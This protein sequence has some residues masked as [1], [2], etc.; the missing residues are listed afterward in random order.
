LLWEKALSELE[1]PTI[2]KTIDRFQVLRLMARGG[3]AQVYEVQDQ[4]TG[5][6]L[7]LKLLMASGHAEDRFNREY[8]AMIRLNHPNIVRVFHYGVHVKTPWFT[9]ELVDGTQAQQRVKQLGVPGAEQ[10]THEAV[11]L[12]GC[13][14]SALRHAH[15][16]GLVHRD[17]KSGNVLVLP[18]GRVKLLDF[19]SARVIDADRITADGEFVG[20]FAYASPEQLMG[21]PADA[22]SDLYSLGVLSYR[23]LVG[24]RPF[25]GDSVH[26][27]SRKHIHE[28]PVPLRKIVAE[29]PAELD[30]L[31]MSLLNK[32][33]AAR[34]RSAGQV[35]RQ[36]QS[37]L[38]EELA[39][40]AE[41][42]I[43]LFGGSLVGREVE[44]KEMQHFLQE[45][46]PGSVCVV[47]GTGGS[48]AAELIR[49]IEQDVRSRDWRVFRCVFNEEQDLLRMLLLLK[50]LAATFAVRRNPQVLRSLDVVERLARNWRSSKVD[51][52]EV[53]RVAGLTLFQERYLVDGRPIVVVLNALEVASIG[54]VKLI[55]S[56]SRDLKR[57][58]VPV[59]FVAQHERRGAGEL[60]LLREEC[61]SVD[62]I[63]LGPLDEWRIGLRVGSFL[64]RRPPPSSVA[65]RILEA[66]GG[67]PEFVEELVLDLV[68]GGLIQSTQKESNRVDWG[69]Q[70]L[71]IRCPA[72]VR[73]AIMADLNGLPRLFLR[74]LEPLAV[75]GTPLTSTELARVIG[76]EEAQIDLVAG[77]LLASTW[78]V[79]S[80]G[81]QTQLFLEHCLI[82]K[83]I[84]ERMSD[85]RR[86]VYVR[87]VID[88][89]S[90]RKPS[91]HLV[92]L[93]VEAD[94]IDEAFGPA[95]ELGAAHLS[96][97]Q[98]RSALEV[99]MPV[100]QRVQEAKRVSR[101]QLARMFLL[102]ARALAQI[103]PL[104]KSFQQSIQRASEL[105]IGP[106]FH[107]ELGL[108]QA[109][110]QKWLGH[111]PNYRRFLTEAWTKLEEPQPPV[112]ASEIAANLGESHTLN[113]DLEVASRWYDWSRDFARKENSDLR[114]AYSEVGRASLF[115][116]QGRLG[117]A[118]RCATRALEVFDHSENVAGMSLA[119][120]IWANTLRHQ[121][122]FSQSLDVLNN[123]SPLLR[124][125][126]VP[127]F[128]VRILISTAR[129]E[130]DLCRLGR[131]QE[132]LDELD[133]MLREG[134]HF[135][136]RMQ[137][138][139]VRGMILLASSQR[140]RAA[141]CLSRVLERASA[142]QLV[143]EAER[144]RAILGEILW[145]DGNPEK[146]QE[147]FN[148]AQSRLA[149]VGHVPGLMDVSVRAARANG[150]VLRPDLIFRPVCTFMDDQPTELVRLEWS[151]AEGE[152]LDRH[153]MDASSA[154]QNARTVFTWIATHLNDTDRTALQLH[155]W[156]RKIRAGLSSG[157]EPTEEPVLTDPD[158]FSL[159]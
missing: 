114:W 76:W 17:L 141:D 30:A 101:E 100:V 133:A 2:S 63:A 127:T 75:A 26:E 124:Q 40:G 84:L 13:V 154:W 134:E 78:L 89:L 91:R 57:E 92:R 112:L 129:C 42:E 68:R 151:I 47:S 93:L 152:Y 86:L 53:L 85:A 138:E 37:M 108:I 73:Q 79:E 54:A 67:M 159:Q 39:Q 158:G 147:C 18:D 132:C 60:D 122:R 146:A 3:T 41:P 125:A 97:F 29:I 74:L 106:E 139:L 58:Q 11:R 6:H 62:L 52:R 115:Y 71:A 126:E 5:E 70:A 98:P 1:I 150:G 103:D 14:A 157:D 4:A 111:Y 140:R 19:G 10:R 119:I 59:L 130:G 155:P 24:K 48:G 80:T 102:H 137:V 44:Q 120:P 25:E 69:Q 104:D 8:E 64:H 12:I 135:N 21:R 131:A 33:P 72:K 20:T 15:E 55:G 9:M 27:I 121:G 23:L 56:W 35:L 107:A 94:R 113:G 117:D 82:G 118:E 43:H 66:S 136:L 149:E 32:Q 46:E 31:V 95:L 65:R 99:L 109:W 156:A 49:R 145:Q 142:A 61:V 28:Q 88:V 90:T 116:A 77:R 143:V 128:F 50:Q 36:I 7:A 34:P 110:V 148:L 123:A 22:R 83:L 96:H 144:A 81:E 38:G 153:G 105:G 45:K 16:R 87:Y 51:H